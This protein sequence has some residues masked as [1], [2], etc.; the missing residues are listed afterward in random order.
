MT[1]K[2]YILAIKSEQKKLRECGRDTYNVIHGHCT[3]V[4]TFTQR[5]LEKKHFKMLQFSTHLSKTLQ[6]LKFSSYFI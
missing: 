2:L 4:R 1:A 6:N 3:Y 5:A